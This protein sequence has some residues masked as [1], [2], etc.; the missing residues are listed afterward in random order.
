MKK[1][2]RKLIFKAIAVFSCLA[3]TIPL[4]S[5]KGKKP[6]PN[7]GADSNPSSTS[8]QE[9]EILTN[10][11]TGLEGFNPEAVGKRPVGVMINNIKVSLPQK[12]ISQADIIYELPV[13]GGI[14]RFLAVFADPSKIPQVGSVRSARHDFLELAM[15]HNAIYIH[16]G[17]SPIAYDKLNSTKWN[18]IDGMSYIKCFEQDKS[19]V[20][21]MGKEHTYFT[22]AQLIDAAIKTKGYDTSSRD[23]KQPDFFK[24]NKKEYSFENFTPCTKATLNFSSYTVSEF[25][26]DATTNKYKKSEYGAAQM[27]DNTKE[28]ISVDNVFVL[29]TSVKMLDEKLKDIELQSGS[30]YYITNGK[31]TEIT[32]EKQG[33]INGGYKFKD[34]KGNELPIKPGNSWVNFISTESKVTLE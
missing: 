18:D 8:S 9:K 25:L 11:L 14:N 17:G 21:K 27:D 32:F 28:Q 1:M 16:F 10:P 22:N 4:S 33:D 7:P 5:C 24:F 34:T 13:E 15:L 30:G 20:G 19:R 26:Y 3:M 12:G 29:Q 6:F 31:K 23:G 2:K